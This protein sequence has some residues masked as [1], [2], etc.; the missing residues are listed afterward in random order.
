M[1][2]FD[3]FERTQMGP[4]ANADSRF[5]WINKC[6]E[7]Y[8]AS[9]RDQFETMVSHYPED[10]RDSLIARIKSD[11]DSVHRSATLE[12]TLHEW[13][14]TQGHKVLAL[15]PHLTHTTKRPD[16][17]VQAKDG[18]EYYLEATARKEDDDHL[19]GIRDAIDDID[20]PVYL[21]VTIS[22]QPTRTL[23]VGKVIRKISKFIAAVDLT[24]D[25]VSWGLLSWE[26]NGVRFR[27]RPLSLKSAKN[28]DARTIGLYSSGAGVVASTGDLERVL[29]TKAGRYGQ[30]AKPYI[31]ATTS[32][33]FT[34]GLYEVTAALF[35]T[36]AVAF[37]PSNPGDPGRLIR[38]SNG[39]WHGR[40]NAWTN[41]GLSAVLHIPDLSMTMLAIRKPLLMI[42]PEPR[43]AFNADWLDAETHAI[44][45]G[46]VQKVKEGQPLGSV[47]NLPA[48]WPE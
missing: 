14:V 43:H 40:P 33:D 27:I 34:T 37:N 15:E 4:A 46:A 20:S 9:V 25:R 35:G 13:V 11:N 32:E 45:D 10:E 41:T 42:H 28:Q 44:I 22:G 24:A 3:D 18:K 5:G 16:F 26:E 23:S 39:I 7:P 36:E 47:L 29:K 38:S 19:A 48:G 31:V 17:L 6:A 12:L 8:A 21:D 30:L 1:I 2:L